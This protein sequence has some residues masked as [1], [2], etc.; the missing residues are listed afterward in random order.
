MSDI[1]GNSMAELARIRLTEDFPDLK[2]DDFY[3]KVQKEMEKLD[4]SKFGSITEMMRAAVGVLRATP[5]A[6][7]HERSLR[8]RR[9]KDRARGQMRAPKVENEDR[10]ENLSR[11]DLLD[12]QLLEIERRHGM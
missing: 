5:E 8:R 1:A 4:A 12:R 10:P 6:I 11:D 7:E 9:R 3:R 2:K